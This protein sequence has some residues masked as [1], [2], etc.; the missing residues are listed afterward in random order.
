MV[1]RPTHAG[2]ISPILQLAD[3][4]D[5]SAERWRTLPTLSSVNRI[6]AAKAGATVLLTGTNEH[7]DAQVVLASQRYGRGHTMAFTVQDTIA[8][9]MDASIPLEDMTHE[10]LWRRLARWLVDGVP[11]GVTITT[12][13]DRV[14]PGEA[15]TLS[16]DVMD[17][18]YLGVND[19]QV[20]AHLTSPSGR[21]VDVPMEWT[22][23]NDGEY[24]G[25]YVPDEDGTWELRVSAARS[26]EGGTKDLGS[27][28]VHIR[29]SNGNSEF[30]GAS[31]REPLLRRIADDTGGR[32]FAASDAAALPEAINY[33]GKG[34]TVVEEHDLW[35]MPIVLILLLG[36][37]AG[38]WALR[39]TRGLA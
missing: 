32:Y 14:D 24:H 1:I 36:A 34:V 5:A 26:G 15:I 20:V 39:R 27:D 28:A 13:Q 19:G 30:F 33:S 9:Q 6:G 21:A 25:T 31:L 8:W 3:T 35:D 22:V 12:R 10:T 16:A 2:E 7:G 11:G 18:E 4:E 37:I 17:G 29:V 23:K 38:E